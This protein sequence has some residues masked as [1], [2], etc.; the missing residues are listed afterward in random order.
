MI[1]TI[2]EMG[3]WFVFVVGSVTPSRIPNLFDAQVQCYRALQTA[4]EMYHL[5]KGPTKTTRTN[6]SFAVSPTN[7]LPRI[8]AFRVIRSYDE[9]PY[10]SYEAYAM[11]Q[12]FGPL[13]ICWS[14]D[15][16]E[17]II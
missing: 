16:Q 5:G 11:S 12:G 17:S 10:S 4:G 1:G 3:F 9:E 15:S 7:F 6:P 13:L 8:V 14:E 2:F